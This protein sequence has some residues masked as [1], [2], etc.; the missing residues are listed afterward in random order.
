M[1]ETFNAHYL[2]DYWREFEEQNEE[3]FRR[4]IIEFL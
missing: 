3:D 4:E 2:E 1:N